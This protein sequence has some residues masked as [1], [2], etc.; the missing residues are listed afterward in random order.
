MWSRARSSIAGYRARLHNQREVVAPPGAP[1]GYRAGMLDFITYDFGYSWSVRYAMIA[2]LIVA[3]SLAALA[4][5]RSWPRWVFIL[6]TLMALWA[7]GAVLVLNVMLNSPMP[8]PTERFLPAG[9]GRVLDVGAGSGR[10]AVGVLIARPHVTAT[11]VDIY[12]GYW[13]IDGN[14]PERFMANARIA[15]VADR[16]SARVG[17][18]RQL[19]FGDG[20]FDAVV[21]SYAI[22]HLPRAERPK[23]IAEVAR[24]LKPGGEFLLMIIRVDWR[25]WLVSPLLAHHPS[26]NPEPW[27]ELLQQHGFSVEEE[28]TPFTTLYFL[29]RKHGATRT[30]GVDDTRWRTDHPRRRGEAQVERARELRAAEAVVHVELV[31]GDRQSERR[32]SRGDIRVARAAGRQAAANATIPSASTEIAKLRRSFGCSPKSSVPA[33][34]P[35]ASANAQPI[36]S[37]TASRSPA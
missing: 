25:T 15:G 20:E 22:D 36:P 27:R 14:T 31:V 19:P 34:R 37:P 26:Q 33:V 30:H 24:V 11:G 18:M 4:A 3:G 17:D 1:V 8:L 32:P 6:A 10:A 2:P 12:S 13:G 16:A 35:M 29:A 21:S 7:A 23:A 9:A 5:W 28:G